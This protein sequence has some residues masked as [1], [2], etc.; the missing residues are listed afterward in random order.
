MTSEKVLLSQHIRIHIHKQDGYRYERATLP[1]HHVRAGLV[2]PTSGTI[3]L[4]FFSLIAGTL[5]L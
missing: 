4:R 3:C 5:E 2:L 1:K